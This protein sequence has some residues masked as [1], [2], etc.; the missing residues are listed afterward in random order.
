MT[1]GE[2]L[3]KNT[4]AQKTQQIVK[5]MSD[6]MDYLTYRIEVARRHKRNSSIMYLIVW[7]T[8]IFAPIW[9]GHGG[10]FTI[11]FFFA[12]V[13]D[14]TFTS[15]LAEAKAEFKGMIN[16]LRILGYISSDH[17][18]ERSRKKRFWEKGVEMVKSWATK[19]KKLQD[20]VFAPA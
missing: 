6:Y 10:L 9:L 11:L 3:K 2:E 19:K 20:K 8:W 16:T 5:E 4:E 7:F 13:I 15:L 17:D 18:G 12:L 1:E 14:C